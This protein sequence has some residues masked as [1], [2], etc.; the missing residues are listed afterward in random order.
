VIFRYNPDK[1][2]INRLKDV[3][4]APRSIPPRWTFGWVNWYS[5]LSLFSIFTK[6]PRFSHSRGH[7][8]RHL[9]QDRLEGDPPVPGRGLDWPVTVYLSMPGTGDTSDDVILWH[10][11]QSIDRILV[12]VVTVTKTLPPSEK[13][14][15]NES[16]KFWSGVT[17]AIVDKQFSHWCLP[18]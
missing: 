8:L 1:D 4:S 18:E 7:M 11:F 17:N 9:P 13:Q 3:E 12:R 14:L 6:I 5:S 2:T 10:I 15:S 16:L